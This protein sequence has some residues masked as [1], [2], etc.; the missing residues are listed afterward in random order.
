[1]DGITK[2]QS[3]SKLLPTENL[4]L[5]MNQQPN[6]LEPVLHWEQNPG[7]STGE[8]YWKYFCILLWFLFYESKIDQY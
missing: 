3:N 4:Q 7:H 6:W 8:V 5:L 2:Q 1:M